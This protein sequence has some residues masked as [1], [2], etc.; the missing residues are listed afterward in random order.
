M[1]LIILLSIYISLFDLRHHRITNLSIVLISALLLIE[2][3]FQIYFL[4]GILFFGVLL[5]LGIFGGVGGGDAKFLVAVALVAIPVEAITTYLT[6]LVAAISILTVLT[7]SVRKRLRGN[8]AL[9]PAICASYLAF[10][11]WQ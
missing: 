1:T 8:I 9:A 7:I 11:L 6:L 4:T 5:L 2:G 3:D 10:L